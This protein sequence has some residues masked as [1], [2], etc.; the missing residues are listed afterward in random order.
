MEEK[1]IK[2]VSYQEDLNQI[3]HN[4]ATQKLFLLEAYVNPLLPISKG[5]S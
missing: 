3:I 5:I 4:S 2:Q 1:N